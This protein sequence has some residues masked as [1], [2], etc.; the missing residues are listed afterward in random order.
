MMPAVRPSSATP[1]NKIRKRFSLYCASIADL[2]P[3][4]V[5]VAVVGADVAVAVVGADIAVAVVGVSGA[6]ADVGVAVVGVAGAGVSGAG[7]APLSSGLFMDIR[8]PQGRYVEKYAKIAAS[9]C[10]ADCRIVPLYP[11]S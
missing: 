8:S 11:W 1:R 4:G 9:F 3:P 7:P 2:G 5:E 10:T 6:E